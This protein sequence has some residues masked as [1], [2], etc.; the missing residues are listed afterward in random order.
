MM[1]G[2]AA[3]VFNDFETLDLFG[4]LEI[5][6]RLKERFDIGLYS[7]AGGAVTS[8]HKIQVVTEPFS[9][10]SRADILFIPGGAGVA[11][12]I[13]DEL[14]IEKLKSLAEGAEYILTVCTGS[15]L[16]SKTGLLDRR[17]ATSNKRLFQWALNES[18]DVCW[19]KKAR[20]I[21]DG[22]TYTSSGI[23]AGIDMTL[24][25]VA[26]LL[27]YNTAKQQ[28]IEIEYLWNEDP[29]FDPFAEIYQTA[30]EEV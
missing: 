23:S 11:K 26:D 20:W 18:P 21:K 9:K 10:I 13:R 19:I 8:S 12:L 14:F 27:D 16:L 2:I 17:D 15:I 22:N 1:R 6:G 28:S 30:G 25:F 7:P 24:G 29:A 3:I 4:P 5:L